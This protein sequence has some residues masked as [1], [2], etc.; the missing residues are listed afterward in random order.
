MP[1]QTFP[2]ASETQAGRVQQA[3]A[4]EVAAGTLRGSTGAILFVSPDKMPVGSS[5]WKLN[6]SYIEPVSSGANVR[7]IGSM[8]VDSLY[9]TT[10]LWAETTFQTKSTAKIGFFGATPIVKPTVNG[11]T[12]GNAALQDLLARLSDL[13][14]ITNSTT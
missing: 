12:G 6:G 11:S 2:N 5:L 13:G 7:A 3:T 9:A 10:M 8:S 1:E 4:A 14:L